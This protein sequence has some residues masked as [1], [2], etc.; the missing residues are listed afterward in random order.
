MSETA[1]Q[2]EPWHDG[3]GR[4]ESSNQRRGQGQ[5]HINQWNQGSCLKPKLAGDGSEPKMVNSGESTNQH[6][7]D[8]SDGNEPKN[9]EW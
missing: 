3:V 2:A 9:G 7:G 5:V 4:W 6:T 1:G 8:W